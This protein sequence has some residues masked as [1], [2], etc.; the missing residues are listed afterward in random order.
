MVMHVVISK[1]FWILLL[2]Y[3]NFHCSASWSK[4]GYRSS[5]TIGRAS[6][7]LFEH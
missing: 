6:L 7:V 1:Q 3:L 4:A 2:Q 5:F